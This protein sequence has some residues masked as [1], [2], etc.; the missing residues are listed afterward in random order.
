[1]RSGCFDKGKQVR[2]WTT[3]DTKGNAYKV[4]KMK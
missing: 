1:M 4:T 2:E 3:Y